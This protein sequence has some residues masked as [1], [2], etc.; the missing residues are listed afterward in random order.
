MYVFPLSEFKAF[1]NR[2][3]QIQHPMKYSTT[4]TPPHLWIAWHRFDQKSQ[5]LKV[6]NQ[7][8]GIIHTKWHPGSD[9]SP[10]WMQLLNFQMK[11]CHFLCIWLCVFFLFFFNH[12]IALSLC[13]HNIYPHA[14]HP[15][16]P[17]AY[18][19][20]MATARCTQAC[21]HAAGT[22]AALQPQGECW[23]SEVEGQRW[24]GSN[25][26]LI[27]LNQLSWLSA[28]M[29]LWYPF[30]FEFRFSCRIIGR[31]SQMWLMKTEF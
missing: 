10:L 7:I 8:K 11:C 28:R 6:H 19:V 2:T 22:H 27:V 24:G 3:L 1:W 23:E 29:H 16:M 21:F 18:E 5:L 13:K 20:A 4:R 14:W 17:V 15:E 9:I 30:V 12:H 31:K 26:G 25:W